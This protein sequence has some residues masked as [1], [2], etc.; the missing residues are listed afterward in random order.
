MDA[1]TTFDWITKGVSLT[2]GMIE[3]IGGT[4]GIITTVRARRKET[5]ARLEDE[6]NFN[7]L[8]AFMAKQ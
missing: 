6:N 3:A 5:D 1:T 2:G 7:M 4:L 8:A